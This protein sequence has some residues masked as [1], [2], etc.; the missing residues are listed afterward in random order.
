M[1]TVFIIKGK[2]KGE[3][4]MTIQKRTFKTDNRIAVE[5]L[6]FGDSDRC[7]GIF[8]TL[9]DAKKAYPRA[10]YEELDLAK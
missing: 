2:T 9:E 1:Y 10:E 7:K 3:M 5:Y 8:E 6:I 4:R